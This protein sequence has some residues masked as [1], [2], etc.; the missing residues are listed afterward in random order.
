MKIEL[1]LTGRDL[2]SV[3][4][5]AFDILPESVG[6]LT[7]ACIDS[8]SYLRGIV[9]IKCRLDVAILKFSIRSSRST[10]SHTKS[11]ASTDPYFNHLLEIVVDEFIPSIAVPLFGYMC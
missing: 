6:S 7:G 10:C 3:A 2:D 11:Q 5:L 8:I 1:V 9:Q 4:F